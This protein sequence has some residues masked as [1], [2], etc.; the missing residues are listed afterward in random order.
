MKQTLKIL[1]ATLLTAALSVPATAAT[2]N[3]T[4]K[5]Q[6]RQADLA[7]DIAS[8]PAV[9]CAVQVIDI[10]LRSGGKFVSRYRADV[11]YLAEKAWLA[12]ITGD[13]RPELVIASS[14]VDNEARGALDVYQIEKNSLR[15]AA[16]PKLEEPSGYRGG[17]RFFLDDHLIVRTFPVYLAGD[18]ANKPSGGS[19]TLKYDF[20]GGKLSLR[21]KQENQ[22]TAA[23]PDRGAATVQEAQGKPAG[24]VISKV[25]LDGTAIEIS[26]NAPVNN[27]KI[28]KLE[29]PER[30]AIDIP[31]AASPLAGKKVKIDNFGISRARVG[32]NRGFLRIVLDS[33]RP[34]FPKYTVT[35]SDSGIK[36]VFE[37]K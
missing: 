23:E 20:G 29:K 3:C 1:A 16:L 19:Q 17:D 2:R 27:F 10:T 11:D 15:R 8:R 9:G 33:T 13:G 25:A 22:A 28:M 14:S 30:I 34:A 4:F 7:F 5:K 32:N 12:D 26:A 31:G 36:V 37:D 21:V 35:R 6:L 18:A 24:T